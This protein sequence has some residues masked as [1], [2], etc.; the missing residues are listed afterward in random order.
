MKIK[1]KDLELMMQYIVKEKPESVDI[2]EDTFLIKFGFSDAE[3]RYC[4]IKL[5]ESTANTTPELVK[6]MKLYTRVKEP[7]KQGEENE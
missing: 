6:S 7:K 5:F 1:T 4:V 3:N 2:N